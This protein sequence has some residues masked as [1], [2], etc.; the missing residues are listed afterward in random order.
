MPR[1][2]FTSL[3]GLGGVAAITLSNAFQPSTPGRV[4]VMPPPPPATAGPLSLTADLD[5]AALADHGTSKRNLVITIHAPEADTDARRLPVDLAVVVD[6]SGS[7]NESGKFVQARR[8]MHALAAQ[9]TDADR[10][11]L[12]TFSSFT[13]T[14]VLLGNA[15]QNGPLAANLLDHMSPDGST[16][17]SG[18]L[19]SGFEALG[20]GETGRVRRVL[21]MTD[22]RA[23]QGVIDTAGLTRLARAKPGVSVSTIGMGLDYDEAMLSAVAD[24]GG[25]DYHYVAQDTDMG[26]VYAEELRSA[27]TLVATSAS[28]DLTFPAGVTAPRACSWTSYALPNNGL[29]VQIG[30][31]SAGQTRTIVIPIEVSPSVDGV[32]ASAI[33][34]ATSPD[35]APYDASTSITAPRVALSD[36]PAHVHPTADAAATLALA[37]DAVD[38]AREA[39]NRGD[40]EYAKGRLTWGSDYMRSKREEGNMNEKDNAVLEAQSA[41]LKSLGYLDGAQGVKAASTVSRKMSR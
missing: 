32:L 25:G 24:A 27:S 14:P 5:Y 2:F 4:E 15:S 9:L 12:V 1:W 21:L 8:A 33:L 40:D 30:D 36:V 17:L 13:S 39:W 26:L 23:N 16:Y 41:E 22:G 31:L 11:A 19:S 35:G 7:M 18:G 34:H 3:L 20:Y 28:L 38:Q 29:R 10:M 6:T 37:G